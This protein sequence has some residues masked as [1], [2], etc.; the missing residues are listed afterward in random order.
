MGSLW[1]SLGLKD[2]VSKE[3]K[4]IQKEF[5]GTDATAKKVQAAISA[6]NKVLNTGN[7][8]KITEAVRGL[9]SVLSASGAEARKL[10]KTLSD[11]KGAKAFENIKAEAEKAGR[12]VNKMLDTF[13]GGDARGM[14]LEQMAKKAS[15][16]SV[17]LSGL[18]QRLNKVRNTGK[19]DGAKG[20]PTREMRESI[21]NAQTYLDLVQRIYL[22][23]KK[24]GETG[25][26]NPNVDTEKL[27]EANRLLEKF[28]STLTE[29]LRRGNGADGSLVL[30]NMPKALQTTM[31]EVHDI[32]N[33]FAKENPLSVFVNG[34]AKTEAAL[35][36]VTERLAKLRDRMAEGTEKGFKTGMLGDGIRELE[37][38]VS[39]LNNAKG[40]GKLLTDMTH[41]KNLLSDVGLEMT[42]ARNALSEYGRE[43]AKSIALSKAQAEAEARVARMAEKGGI[44]LFAKNDPG[45]K[46]IRTEIDALLERLGKV[47]E[48]ITLYQQA[49]DS[50][51]K[52]S[53]S[54]G[55]QGLR[56]ANQEAERLMVT[57]GALQRVYDTLRTS[58]TNVKDLVGQTPEKQRQ[59]DIQRRMS[60]YYRN[61]EK[62][63]AKDAAQAA[64]DAEKA[65][66]ADAAAEKQRQKE[67]EVTKNRVQSLGFALQKLWGEHQKGRSLDI[68]TT[69]ADAKIR[70]MIG[71]IRTLRSILSFLGGTDYR[72]Y[73]GA[74]GQTGNGRSVRE[75]SHIAAEQARVNAEKAKSVELERKH[76]QETAKTAAKVRSD[77]ARAFEQAKEKASGLSSTMQDLKSLFLQGGIV[78]G[79]QQFVMS[80]IQTGGELEKQHIAL[81]S[82]LGDMQNANTMFAQVKELALNSPFTFSELNRDVKQLAAYGVEYDDLYDTTKRLADMASGLGVS[83]ERIALAF[84]QVQARGWL[85]GKELRQIAYAGIPLLE[86]LSEY[87]SKRE[88][89][90]V[91]TSEVKTRISGRGVDFEDVKNIFWEMTDAGGQFYNMQQVLSETLLG[92]YNKLKDAWEIMLSEF[93]SGSSL[94]GSGLKKIIDLVTW[95]VQ[96]L[97]TMAPV[98][99]SAF[100]GPLLGRMGKAIGGGFDK[101]LLS[102]KGQMAN[103]ATRKAMEGK[104]LNGVERDILRTK[105]QITA[106]DIRNL[107]KTNALTKTELRR[108]YVSGKITQEMYEQGMA[109]ESQNAQSKG[110]SLMGLFGGWTGKGSGAKWGA[111]GGL[112][113]S[114]LKSIG[115]TLLGFFGGLPGIAISAGAAIFAYYEQKNAELKQDMEQS[116]NELKD[117]ATQMGEFLR[118]NDADK[119]IASGDEKAIDNMI[120]S[121]E[122]K[123]REI[124]PESAQA[125][126]MRADEIASHKE[127]LKY[128]QLQLELVR[129]ANN[130]A[131]KAANTPDTYEKLRNGTKNAS[132]ATEAMMKAAAAMKSVNLTGNELGIYKDAKKDF[133]QYIEYLGEKYKK[134]FKDIK[135]SQE[136][137]EAFRALRDNMLAAVGVSE[138]AA[139]QIRSALNRY[140]GLEDT[141]M[142]TAFANKLMNMVDDT[143]P[144][145][146]DRIRSHK[147]LDEESKK[148]VDS[149]MRGAV[150]QLSLDYPWWEE[151]LQELLRKSNFEARIRLVY[152][153][154]AADAFDPFTQRVYNNVLGK[155]ITKWRENAKK[156]TELKP[157]LKGV[158]DMYTARN[159]AKTELDLRYNRWQAEEDAKKKG[160]GNEAERKMREKSYKDLWSA[161]YMGLGYE[162]IP[163]GKKSNKTPKTKEHQEDKELKAL[164]QRLDDF[165]AARQMYQKLVKETGMGKKGA[166]NEVAGLFPDIN[167]KELNLDDYTGSIGRLM[168]GEGFWNTTERKKFRTQAA[169]EMADWKISEVLKPEFDRVS[170]NFKEALEKGVKHADLEKELL[171]KTGNKD[172]AKL[173]W[174]DGAVWDEQ[175][176]KMLDNFRKEAGTDIDLNMTDADAKKLYENNWKAYALWQ[177]ITAI[178]KDK[179]VKSLQSAADIMVETATTQEKLAAIDAKYAEKI[180]GARAS[181]N[182]SLAERY[183]QAR[184]KEKGQVRNEAFKGSADYLIFF[185]AIDALGKDKAAE[186][187]T[188][189]RSQLNQALADGSLDAREYAK[190][191]AQVEEQLD[192]LGNGR[193][194]LW[195]DGFA[196]SAEQKIADGKTRY[197]VGWAEVG[198]GEKKKREGKIEGDLEKQTDGDIMIQ[199]GKVLM[200]AGTEL[201]IAGRKVKEGWEDAVKVADKVDANVQGI[202]NAFNDVKD[203]MGA[204]GFD[205]ESDGWQDATAVFSSLSGMSSGVKNAIN[206]F[207]TGDIGGGIAGALSVVTSPIKAF[208][209]AHDA[210]LDREIKLAEREV[211]A[212]ER[213]SENVKSILDNML[214]GVYSYTMDKDTRATLEKV[215]KSYEDGTKSFVAKRFGLKSS[216]QY[217][218]DTYD[219]V[220]KSLAEPT[221]A[222]Q[223][224]YASL[225]AQRDEL[226]RQRNAENDKKKKD[227]DKIAD[228][229]QQIKE[230]GMT[231]ENFS[232]DF[233][234]DIYGIDMKNWASQLTDAVVSAWEKGEDAMDAYRKKAK[235]LVKDL[236][237]NIVSQKVMEKAMEAPLK[238]LEEELQKNN[239]KLEDSTIPRLVDMLADAGENATYS[240]T[241]IMDALKAQGYDFTDAGTGGVS[242]SVKNITEETADVLAS[243]MNAIRLDVSVNRAQV[244][245]IGELLQEQMPEMGQIQKAQLG[246]LTQ[247]VVL[248]EARNAKLD[249]MKDWMTGVTTG[250]RKKVYVS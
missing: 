143:F 200:Q 114:G 5:S 156:F 111:L 39:R 208:S 221:N 25:G 15:D 226:Q 154:G 38:L 34:A 138:E 66:R 247:L 185:E 2:E 139:S 172:F 30:G 161:A 94:M 36:N 37:G 117:R 20:D 238:Y 67:I 188:Q 65:K 222:Y 131:Q 177:K 225:L 181:G 102:A 97:H 216:S 52:E 236:T 48:D 152:D 249:W 54:F 53:M 150:G 61:L 233:L 41:M 33:S 76:Q 136:Q 40:N 217:G 100:A 56:E 128:L 106:V 227:K 135:N 64:N 157:L 63:A 158:T 6:I 108:L 239:G 60:E 46:N 224:E 235:E 112:I 129:A 199:A 206:G 203:T 85:D 16:Y 105:N 80:V 125:F 109:L 248:A 101:A 243:Y 187:A 73:L 237:K 149:L 168:P 190:Q 22:A 160:K 192:K 83:F 70:G 27:K 132:E 162:Y 88:G 189:I 176:R 89:R 165:K 133:D 170:A 84:G 57:I 147:E 183:V 240:I 55:Q 145:I 71:E 204:L 122:E 45:L 205:T 207:A 250:G 214:G 123:L 151:S 82:I 193:K 232:K 202:V 169:R 173:A 9:V 47:R 120:D 72:N 107:A 62:T 28:G 159:N 223:A 184:D 49:I 19:A 241:K 134:E 186:T 178:V 196:G 8:T 21:R 4:K 14:T 182:S 140:L 75:A 68:D 13:L 198:E 175:T 11:I 90:K 51:S 116:L 127:R 164:Q 50:G 18:E 96:S 77:L 126:K 12:A 228:Y 144:D 1:M 229:D 93:A 210:K 10:E 95:L 103:E 58:Q 230:M 3:L 167:W 79:A 23:Q 218:E 146:A 78:Y 209:A 245:A 121:Y 191:I 179:Y 29:M 43:K 201:Q 219:A 42:K 104:K 215:K 92:R 59:D 113:G 220:Q 35:S 118:D 163:D 44:T 194:T 87:Y 148:K 7:D 174:T 142:E 246:Q 130:E 74:I 86:K 197:N 98:L 81:Q 99:A 166:R 153:T 24:V 212:L 137:Q 119:T 213:M 242:N 195:S 244:K 115:S 26:K 69:K 171:E 155:D 32:L 234:K 31:R 231:I 110:M 211:T 91:S 17:Q 124:S 141:E 180:N